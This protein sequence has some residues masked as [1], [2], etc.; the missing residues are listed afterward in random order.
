MFKATHFKLWVQFLAIVISWQFSFKA[1]AEDEFFCGPEEPVQAA[2]VETLI[3]AL[4][5][6]VS[7]APGATKD[8]ALMKQLFAPHA[9]ITPV[10]HKGDKVIASPGSVDSFIALNKELFKDQGFYEQEVNHQIFSFG[11]MAHVL[12]AY[13]S[14]RAPDQKP[15]ARGI[16]S[17][18][19]L[20]DG[21]RWCVLS[22][23]WDSESKS[24]PLTAQDLNLGK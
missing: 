13:E 19:L 12:S 3:P 1:L 8:W 16:N 2:K 5:Q 15:Y 20:N 17:F 22:V 7:G 9:M 6:I 14:R 21:R 10:F 18:Q 11:H 4:Y 23:T 24:H